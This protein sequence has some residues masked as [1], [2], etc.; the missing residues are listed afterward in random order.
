MV[1]P[2]G[3]HSTARSTARRSVTTPRVDPA[4]MVSRRPGL[5]STCRSARTTAR[6]SSC[7]S[8]TRPTVVW[9]FPVSTSMT[10]RS[11][12]APRRC[13]TTAPR[14]ARPAFA[15][16]GFSIVG[17]TTT[18]LFDNYYVMG[19][20]SYVSYDKYLLTGP[21]NFGFTNTKPDWVEHYKYGHGL[22]ISYW[23]TSVRRQQHQPAPRIGPQPA[24]RRQ[25]DADHQHR[26]GR[27]VAR[28]NPGVRRA[29]LAAQGRLDDAAHQR[30]CQL[31]P[32][33]G[34]EAAVRRHQEVLVR[35]AP[36]PRRQAASSRRQGSGPLGEGDQR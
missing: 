2:T 20:R 29:V 25:P 7:G 35:G 28:A 36:Q 17:A 21:Y 32:G 9:P 4:S 23:D 6:R 8:T 10:S 5:T 15:L 1:A 12:P 30:C 22:L 14:T 34:C 19:H 18:A 11:R 13:W 24:D 31:H 27:T 33:S 26:D 16:D 3:R